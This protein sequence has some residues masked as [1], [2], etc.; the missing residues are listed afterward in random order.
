ML[1][2][3]RK[4]AANSGAFLREMFATISRGDQRRLYLREL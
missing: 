4:R 1:W 2:V 3:P